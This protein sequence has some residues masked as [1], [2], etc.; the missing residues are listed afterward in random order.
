MERDSTLMGVEEG[1]WRVRGWMVR[2][3]IGRVVVREQGA[4]R[5]VMKSMVFLNGKGGGGG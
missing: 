5:V 4:R 2:K 3:S 1:V